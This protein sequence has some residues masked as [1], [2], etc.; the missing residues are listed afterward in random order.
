MR[1]VAIVYQKT[2]ITYIELE[3]E[4]EWRIKYLKE[5]QP[6]NGIIGVMLNR[7]PEYI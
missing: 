2:E 5:Q 6:K 7:G 1:N 3:K 4:I